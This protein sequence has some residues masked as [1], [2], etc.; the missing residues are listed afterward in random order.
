MMIHVILQDMHLTLLHSNMHAPPPGG[1]PMVTNG[2]VLAST[3]THPFD[4]VPLET[5]AAS[6]KHELQPLCLC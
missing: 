6:R 4:V 1:G 3:Q 5:F 2:G